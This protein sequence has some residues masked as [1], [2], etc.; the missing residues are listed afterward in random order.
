[1]PVKPTPNRARGI[2]LRWLVKDVRKLAFKARRPIA[3]ILTQE[4]IDA[5]NEMGMA[6]RRRDE[7]YRMAE[8][9]KVNLR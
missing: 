3:D 8:A 1:M 4:I 5:S 9:S 6:V 2:A 7:M